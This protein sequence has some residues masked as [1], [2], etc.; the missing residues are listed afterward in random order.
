MVF[1]NF[2][3]SA[4][5]AAGLTALFDARITGIALSALRLVALGSPARSVVDLAAR[6]RN[7]NTRRTPEGGVTSVPPLCGSAAGSLD[8]KWRALLG[9]PPATPWR[10]PRCPRAFSAMGRGGTS[11]QEANVSGEQSSNCARGMP[12]HNGMASGDRGSR[13]G[14]HRG[15]IC[16][17][18]QE[19]KRGKSTR[20]W[21]REF[22]LRVA[23]HDAQSLR[24][25]EARPLALL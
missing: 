3:A 8:R 14:G 13:P 21:L 11:A 15:S 7:G 22:V 25:A 5:L 6:R 4:N 12:S 16:G 24:L 23:A 19:S 1:A 9:P 10:P 18:A 17:R 2:D 20:R